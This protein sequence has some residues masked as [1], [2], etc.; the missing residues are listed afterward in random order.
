MLSKS[1]QS[2]RSACS[3]KTRNSAQSNRQYHTQSSRLTVHGL[4]T[5]VLDLPI[6]TCIH[7]FEDIVK[8]LV[9]VL[10]CCEC[11]N[12]PIWSV[13][14]APTGH[15]NDDQSFSTPFEVLGN[16]ALPFPMCREFSTT[17]LSVSRGALVT[18]HPSRPSSLRPAACYLYGLI[19]GL[20]SQQSRI[21]E[22]RDRTRKQELGAK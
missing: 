14:G 1:C 5:I 11:V 17:L 7:G 4:G 20:F 10:E 13:G 15:T 2:S 9:G 18:P 6:S 19:L 3:T 8:K 16:R 12:Q 21:W 22:D